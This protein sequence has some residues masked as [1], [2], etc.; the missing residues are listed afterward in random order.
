MAHKKYEKPKNPN[1]RGTHNR[2]YLGSW[3]SECDKETAKKNRKFMKA[4]RHKILFHIP[5]DDVEKELVECYKLTADTGFDRNGNPNREYDWKN[6]EY[7]PRSGTT[8]RW[9]FLDPKEVKENWY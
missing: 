7:K 1:K 6:N 5:L 3:E 4:L 2:P 9:R 8:N